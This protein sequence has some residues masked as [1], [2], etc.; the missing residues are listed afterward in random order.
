M[1]TLNTQFKSTQDIPF[2]N[3][4]KK[5]IG[6]VEG[7]VTKVKPRNVTVTDDAGEEYIITNAVFN[8]NNVHQVEEEVA[9][10]EEVVEETVEE[11]AP[12]K[13]AKSK[14]KDKK[15]DVVA[16]IVIE[17][18]EEQAAPVEVV[19]TEKAEKPIKITSKNCLDHYTPIVF[20]EGETRKEQVRYWK[21]E[22]VLNNAIISI[23]IG[24]NA[25]YTQRLA[26]EIKAED[27]TVVETSDVVE[28]MEE[29]DEEVANDDTEEVQ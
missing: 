14:A 10:I 23:L 2:I 26:S 3:G 8:D 9:P 12:A 18:E 27:A 19:E 20:A 15:D 1:I 29:L 24:C 28:E 21:N 17:Q 7:I 13:K 5:T 22:G 4:G 25:A 16:P 11:V 6:Q